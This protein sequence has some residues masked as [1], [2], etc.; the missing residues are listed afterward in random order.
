M[1]TSYIGLVKVYPQIYTDAKKFESEIL[2]VPLSKGMIVKFGKGSLFD[3]AIIGCHL[4]SSGDFFY[5]PMFNLMRDTLGYRI[6]SNGILIEFD[7]EALKQLLKSILETPDVYAWLAVKYLVTNKYYKERGDVDL[8][9]CQKA[10]EGLIDEPSGTKAFKDELKKLL[11]KKEINEELLDFSAF[12]FLH[13]L[14]HMVYEY[15]VDYLKT[16]PDN[17]AYHIDRK[18][19]KVYLIENAEKGLGLTETLRDSIQGTEKEFFTDFLKWSLQ[20][21]NDCEQHKNKIKAL[22]SKELSEKILRADQERQKTFGEIDYFVKNVNQLMRSEYGIDFPVEILRNTLV[23]K[24]GNDPLIMEAI[25]SN[26]SYCWDGCYN[27][28]RLDKGC[29]YDPFKQTT[30]VSKRLFTEVV[31]RILSNMEI[32]IQVGSGFEWILEEISKTKN[33]LRISSPWLSKDIIEKYIEPLLK[34]DIQVKVVTRKDL[35]NEEQ[36]ESLSY[37]GNLVKNYKSINVKHL[38]SLHAKMI[39]IDDKI[40]IKGSMNLTFSGI[41]KNVE[42]V[43]KYYKQEIVEKLVQDFES[44]FNLANKL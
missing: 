42:L 33:I 30:R 12:V 2:N 1:R 40:G 24:F 22:A 38:D 23:R 14:S 20:V 25:V 43:E 32:P 31:K 37:L 17:I 35:N 8:E 27:C 39:L 4:V 19:Y 13:S 3:R 7:K 15:I 41:Y 9:L 16:D 5:S 18:E 10:F 11:K 6:S 36:V 26:V 44:I 34:K 29:N 28:V 21:I